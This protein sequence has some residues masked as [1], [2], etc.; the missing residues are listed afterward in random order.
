MGRDTVC[1]P[2]PLMSTHSYAALFAAVLLLLFVP[3]IH[4]SIQHAARY[5]ARHFI[6]C[7][8]H[9]D[10]GGLCA[11]H[12]GGRLPLEDHRDRLQVLL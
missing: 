1:A 8:G 6:P 5:T 9:L 3:C 11:A 12:A 2:P 4:P 7:Q 10:R